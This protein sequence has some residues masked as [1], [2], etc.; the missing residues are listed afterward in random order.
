MLTPLLFQLVRLSAV[1]AIFLRVVLHK[2]AGSEATLA[3]WA[4][5]FVILAGAVDAALTAMTRGE[6]IRVDLVLLLPSRPARLMRASY[7][8]GASKALW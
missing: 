6:P 5:N 3:R 1:P 8:R 7:F 2:T 4:A